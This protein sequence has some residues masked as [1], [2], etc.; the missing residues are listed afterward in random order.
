MTSIRAG[1]TSPN[2]LTVGM[3]QGCRQRSRIS[4]GVWVHANCIDP[5]DIAE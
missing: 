5:G 2:E 1:R 3:A 4:R